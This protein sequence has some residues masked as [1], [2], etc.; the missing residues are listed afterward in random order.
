MLAR[1]G[2]VSDEPIRTFLQ[3]PPVEEPDAER[4]HIVLVGEPVPWEELLAELDEDE[5]PED[6]VEHD[7]DEND[8]TG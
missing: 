1:A 6:S 2:S 7:D 3:Q 5:Q 4:E 8:V